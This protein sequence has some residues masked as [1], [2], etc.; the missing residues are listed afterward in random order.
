MNKSVSEIPRDTLLD[1]LEGRSEPKRTIDGDVA[2]RLRAGQERLTR[3][4]LWLQGLEE[5]TEGQ[6]FKFWLN[7]EK[8]DRMEREAREAG[9]IEGCPIGPG[10]CHE[11]APIRCGHCAS[12][13]VIQTPD[14]PADA[15]A[16]NA[17]DC[18]TSAIMGRFQT[19][20]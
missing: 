15:P 7:Y 17:V 4:W 2:E 9:E 13:K 8:W 6:E 18:R 1:A 14:V 10:G 16:S 19:W 12:E 11:D 5:W 3:T 20:N